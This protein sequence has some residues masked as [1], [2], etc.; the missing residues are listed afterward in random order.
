MARQNNVFP[1][2]IGQTSSNVMETK[3]LNEMQI[4]RQTFTQ[5]QKQSLHVQ[6][7]VELPELS[8]E[9]NSLVRVEPVQV[10]G[11]I[12]RVGDEEFV[13]TINQETTATFV[14]SRCLE[15]FTK[16]VKTSWTERLT[17]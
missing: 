5:M 10:E 15:P 7:E 9:V 2:L 8:R 1:L 6:G 3:G 14:C 4:S 13:A 17:L 11:V 12:E 16:P